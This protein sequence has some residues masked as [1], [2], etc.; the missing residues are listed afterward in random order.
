MSSCL[1]LDRVSPGRRPT[2]PPSGTQRWR[3]LLFVHY[4]YPLD[5]VRRLVPAE[6]ELDPW[7]DEAWVG[8]VPFRME[9]IRPRFAPFGI[10][11]LE[12]NLRTYVH[13]QGEPGI[14]FFSLE[15]SSWLAVQV[16]RRGWGLPYFHATMRSDRAGTRIDYRTRRKSGDAAAHYE[17]ELQTHGV[18]ATPGTL[19]H[20]LLERYLLFTA[21]QG[22]VHKGH[23]HH[24]PYPAA[25]TTLHAHSDTVV[26]AAGLP[27]PGAPAAVHYAA[28]VDVE[29]FGPFRV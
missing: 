27:S 2:G 11:F 17:L 26:V 24:T 5:L 29:V 7:N 8:V 21:T 20:F 28:G 22:R 14:F 3:E 6:L 9:G 23:V 12:F 4:T 13:Y 10:D 19:D 18:A 15:A 16:A 25:V 1:D